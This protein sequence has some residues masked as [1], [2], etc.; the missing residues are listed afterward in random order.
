MADA[1]VLGLSACA[2]D[3]PP[4]SIACTS[5]SAL[6]SDGLVSLMGTGVLGL[7]NGVE[8]DIPRPLPLGGGGGWPAEAAL[9]LNGEPEGGVKAATKFV[10]AVYCCDDKTA[11]G[12]S[13]L[14]SGPTNTNSV[15]VATE[16]ERLVTLRAL[17]SSSRS[18]KS[19]I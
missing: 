8:G 9:G 5:C 19:R 13:G 18:D 4:T 17:A 1:S 3:K 16:A 10:I 2:G 14:K 6:G 15:F 11:R 7:N 12:S